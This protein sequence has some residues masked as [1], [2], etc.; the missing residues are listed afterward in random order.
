[1]GKGG[2]TLVELLV[3]IAVL[4]IL[5]GIGVPYMAGYRNRVAHKL[6]VVNLLNTRRQVEA[7]SQMFPEDFE[8]KQ[9]EE[10]TAVEGL[11][12]YGNW[13]IP[14][15]QAL[16]VYDAKG[17]VDVEEGTEMVSMLEMP[18]MPEGMKDDWEELELQEGAVGTYWDSMGGQAEAVPEETESGERPS[19]PEVPSYTE[20][21]GDG[22]SETEETE[23]EA[24]EP[25]VPAHVCRDR[26]KDCL[27]DTA[28]CGTVMHTETMWVEDGICTKCGLHFIH[29]GVA[30]LVC[31]TCWLDLMTGQT[32]VCSWEE[33]VC[34]CR[35]G[36]SRCDH[37]STGTDQCP[38]CG[39]YDYFM[40]PCSNCD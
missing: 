16:G 34:L 22:A 30:D 7:I 21:G 11:L 40:D 14:A 3:V 8:G 4:A 31:D 26:D 24:A 33:G 10:V 27:C 19:A 18:A 29:R 28:G 37:G 6:N 1:M 13:E 36:T 23:E 32:H 25:T 39:E 35:C 17:V 2:F 38:F 9:T 12:I 20:P 5:A 15:P